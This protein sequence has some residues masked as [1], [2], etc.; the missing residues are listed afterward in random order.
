MSGQRRVGIHLRSFPV[1]SEAFV[2]EQ[3]RT[4]T[5]F[6]PVLLVRQ[7]TAPCT[8]PI[9]A[10][11]DASHGGWRRRLFALAPGAWAFGGPQALK[12]LDL[13]HAHFGPNGAYAL[14]MA[15]R[16]G[17]PLVTTFHG[18]DATVDRRNLLTEHGLYGLR[19][20]VSLPR[21]RR[22]GRLFLAVSDFLR[23]RLLALG[24]PERRVR[25]HYIGVDIDRF[26]PLPLEQRRPDIVCVARLTHAKGV[27]DLIRAFARVAARHPNCRLRLV[28]AGPQRAAF[29]QLCSELEVQR[30]VVFEGT[31]P[32]ER[33]AALLRRC[34][35]GVLASRR[36]RDGWQEAF[37]LA[38]IEAAAAGLPVLVTRNGG[39]PE[40]VEQD[41]TGAVVDEGDVAAMADCLDQWLSQPTMAE[42]MGAAGRRRVQQRFSLRVQTTILEEH[43][44]E[45]LDP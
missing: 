44:L 7:Q 32:H 11:S 36:G 40:A 37:G 38:A 22:E 8:L 9:R 43:Y 3:A 25:R 14:P 33:V 42:R 27:G 26:V 19:F 4:L 28:G 30:Q 20:V 6:D 29:E 17:L 34:S 45:A 2:M 18:F 35:V 23:D 10:L 39:L 41:R 1:A 15:R 24:F 31:M 5:R 16:L 13:L 21:L 12:D